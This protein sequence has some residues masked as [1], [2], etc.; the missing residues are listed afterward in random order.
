MEDAR[1]RLRRCAR[2]RQPPVRCVHATR[3]EEDED[4]G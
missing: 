3:E 1:W 2:G 4:C